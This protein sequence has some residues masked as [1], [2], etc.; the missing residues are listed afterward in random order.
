MSVRVT[1]LSAYADAR[2]ESY[3]LP[4]TLAS[5]AEC[6]IATVRPGCIR[7]NHVHTTRRELLAVLYTDRWTLFWDEGEGTD[8]QSRTFEG[9]G[10]VL[11]DV[12]PD[13]AHAVR[14]DGAAELQLVSI[15][16]T[17]TTDTKQRILAK[18][19]TK[20][21]GLDGCNEGWVAV[22]ED[23]SDIDAR[24]VRSDEELI[25]LFAQCAVVAID[26]PIGLT[27]R[28]GRPCDH[29]ARRHLGNR[30]SSV[31]SAPIRDILGIR[32][33]AEANRVSREIQGKGISKQCF[34]I[35]PKIA[36]IDRILQR[37]HELR[38]RVYEVHPEV[39]FAVWNET[40]IAETKHTKAGLAA[41]RALIESHFDAVPETPRGAS[42]NDLLD[43]M[44]ALWTARRIRAGKSQSFGDA[45]V[46]VT[47]L[48]MRIVY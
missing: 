42:E 48:P 7:G 32:E 8:V 47:G 15:G 10:A 40:P 6:H 34:M 37:H 38:S 46:D 25:A 12:D 3:S 2:G 14:N 13:C 1:S 18:P 39:S 44:A 23:E 4:L 21:A 33:Y 9:R 24:I 16:D 43:A 28:G 17:A 31:F 30:A 19:L 22:I 26:I 11:M 5:F 29:H 45:H 35:V 20:L 41:R 27:Q 36:Q